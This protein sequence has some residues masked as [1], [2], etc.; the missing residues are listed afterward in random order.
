MTEREMRDIVSDLVKRSFKKVV[1]PAALGLGLSLAAGCGDTG[2]T[3]P[4]DEECQ[5]GKC[6]KPTMKY[7]APFAD[8]GTAH[9]KYMGPFADAGQPT[10]KYMG[11][12]ADA[13]QPTVKYMGPFADAGQAT[14]KYMGPFADAGT[15]TTK[16][17][18]P[19]PDAGDE[20]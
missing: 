8:A 17:M 19:F 16:Y 3:L 14:M 1:L 18:G 7:M 11:P 9:V 20:K 2:D 4:P 13:G 6:D 10:M 15:A 5:T 12:F